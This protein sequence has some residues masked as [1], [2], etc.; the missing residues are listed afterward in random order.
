MSIRLL[1]VYLLWHN[2]PVASPIQ[3]PGSTHRVP[4]PAP[5]ADSSSAPKLAS[6]AYGVIKRQ[7][8]EC[9]LPPGAEVTERELTERYKVGKAPLREALVAL[10]HEGLVRPMPR[11]GYVITPVTIQDVQD[12]FELRLLL[13]PAAARRATGK[14]DRDVLTRMDELCR[15]GYSP[16]NRE[17]ETRFLQVN[18]LFHVT[19]A[20]ASGN[21]RLA[22]VL[23]Q[24][25][26]QMERLFHLGLQVRDRSVEMQHEHEALVD[27]LARGDADTAERVTVAQIEAARRMVMDGILSAP[28]LKD[29]AIGHW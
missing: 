20:E 12:I 19:I 15:A 27:A 25:L 21:R 2:V 17:S 7:I 10:A 16:G 1:Q 4:N 6:A 28:W 23:A 14:V 29:L 26:E 3:A 5:G 8:V 11:R 18:R 24:L 22:A 9:L 13:E